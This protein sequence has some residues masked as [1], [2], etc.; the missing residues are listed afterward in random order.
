MPELEFVKSLMAIGN[1]L[2]VL[3]GKDGKTSRLVA[4]LVLLNLNLPARVWLPLG[5][6]TATE[7]SNGRILDDDVTTTT[8][9]TTGRRAKH[10]V[11]RIPPTAG[12]VLNSKD[13]VR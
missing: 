5:D 13:K 2:R 1:R 6:Y 3:P 8:T 7:F 11:V 9:K 4:E 10:Y 12:V